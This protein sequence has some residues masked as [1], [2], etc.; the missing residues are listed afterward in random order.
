MARTSIRVWTPSLRVEARRLRAKLLEHYDG[1]GRADSVRI[2][3][4]K[5]GYAPVFTAAAPPAAVPVRVRRT[6]VWAAMAAVGIAAGVLTF[7]SK[8]SSDAVSMVVIPGGNAE[9]REFGDGLAEALS[10]ELSRNPRVHVVAWPLFVE[11]RQQ[12]GGSV[13]IAV[14][15]TAQD[16]RAD[17][18]LFLSIRRSGQ[19]RRVTAHLMN[20]GQGWKRWAGDYERGLDD[21]FA[22]QRELARAMAD[23]VLAGLARRP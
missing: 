1:P 7:A 15:R 6:W 5:G 9:D 2:M 17:V 23:E 19:R 21:G 11:Y 13:T 10:A 14:A 8:A 18:V 12:H 16:L 20:A 22:V 3:M 4:P